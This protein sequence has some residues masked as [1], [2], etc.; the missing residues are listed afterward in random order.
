[1]QV[2]HVKNHIISNFYYNLITF[3]MGS[4]IAIGIGIVIGTSSL[5]KTKLLKII[6]QAITGG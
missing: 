4:L 5:G 1:M 6:V 2:Q 3:I